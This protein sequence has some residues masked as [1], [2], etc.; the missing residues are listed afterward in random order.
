MDGLRPGLEAGLGGG[1]IM[2]RPEIIRDGTV[3]GGMTIL[4]RL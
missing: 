2:R 1:Q 3:L 4:H